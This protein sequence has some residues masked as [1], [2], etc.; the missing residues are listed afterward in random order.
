MPVV[1]ISREYTFEAAHFLPKVDRA[2]KCHRIHGHSYR[3]IVT[4]HGPVR[5]DG[6]V[7]DF[8]E[9]DAAAKPII[10]ALDHQYLNSL[11]PNPTS[12]LIAVELWRCLADSLPLAAVTVSETARSSATFRGEVADVRV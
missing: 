12:E 5:A 3:V 6:M 11:F 2:H 4:V 7:M 10:D 9:V 1:E 8:A